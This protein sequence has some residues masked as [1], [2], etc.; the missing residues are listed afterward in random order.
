MTKK[1][2]KT[3]SKTNTSPFA[4][5]SEWRVTSNFKNICRLKIWKIKKKSP[6]NRQLDTFKVD[7]LRERVKHVF[8]IEKNNRVTGGE[9]YED[10]RNRSHQTDNGGMFACYPPFARYS[11]GRVICFTVCFCS[12]FCQRFLDNPPADSR[13]I[14]HAGVLWFRMCLLPFCGLAAPGVEKGGN[15]ECEWRVCVSST[16]TLVFFYYLLPK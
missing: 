10:K 4:L 11:E 2:T 15:V 3:Y 16:D 8:A 7:S 14:L 5:T 6:K 13:Q 9:K 12:L 1:R